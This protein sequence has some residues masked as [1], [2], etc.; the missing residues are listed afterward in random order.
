MT[1]QEFYDDCASFSE[2][3]ELCEEYGCDYLDNVIDDDTYND[4]VEEEIRDW[5]DGWENLRSYL[6]DLPSYGDSY[7]FLRN[8]PLDYETV[9]DQEFDSYQEDVA[10]WMEA[11]GYFDEEEEESE[12]EDDDDGIYDPG[13]EASEKPDEIDDTVD[14]FRTFG[15]CNSRFNSIVADAENAKKQAQEE[16]EAAFSSFVCGF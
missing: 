10:D 15:I 14:L 9:S 1:R 3:K 6:D 13:E 16:V 4:Y 8:G 2:L 12:E 5:D 7:W 11:N